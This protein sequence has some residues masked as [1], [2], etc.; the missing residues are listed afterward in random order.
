MISHPCDARA[1]TDQADTGL[2]L[3][4]LRAAAKYLR[5]RL[6]HV[7][8]VRDGHGLEKQYVLDRA[9]RDLD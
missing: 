8:E 6:H 7:P 5:V 1:G 3:P 2:C 4:L 9:V